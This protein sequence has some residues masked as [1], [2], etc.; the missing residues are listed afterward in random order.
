MYQQKT[1]PLTISVSTQTDI[2]KSSPIKSPPKIS[3]SPNKT[4]DPFLG[5]NYII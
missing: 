5:L 3:K 1:A 4:N 2:I